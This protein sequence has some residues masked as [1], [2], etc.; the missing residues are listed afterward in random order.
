MASLAATVRPK[1]LAL[2]PCLVGTSA[3]QT[4][5]QSHQLGAAESTVRKLPQ[6]TEVL[7]LLESPEYC[8]GNCYFIEERE[9]D[10]VYFMRWL[11]DECTHL[12]NYPPPVEIS[13]GAGGG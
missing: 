6:K 1:F 13:G 10:C 9:H 4:F 11:M 2:V 7:G 3:S 8:P 5:C 12:G